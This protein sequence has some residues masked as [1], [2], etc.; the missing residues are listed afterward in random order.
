MD[1]KVVHALFGLFDQRFPKD[2]PGEIFGHAIHFFERLVNG[3][4]A[5]GAVV[6]KKTER[7]DKAMERTQERTLANSAK[8]IRAFH[9][10]VFLYS[11]P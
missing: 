4:S 3:D 9:E 8:S 10:Y 11:N 1:G 5:D 6:T 2:F 7:E